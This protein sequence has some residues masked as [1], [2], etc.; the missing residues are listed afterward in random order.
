MIEIFKNLV[1]D[2]IQK[3]SDWVDKVG[4]DYGFD[5]WY[6]KQLEGQQQ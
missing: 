3:R 4:S 5:E 6:M 2:Y 1:H